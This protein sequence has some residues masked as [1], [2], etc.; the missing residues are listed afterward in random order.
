MHDSRIANTLEVVLKPQDIVVALRLTLP[1]EPW[2]YVTL[3][4]ALHMSPSEAHAAVKRASLAGLVDAETKLARR[5]SLKEFLVHGLKY[6]VPP[7]WTPT[8]RGVPTA[9]AMSPLKA[10]ITDDGSPPVWPHAR[11]KVRGVGLRPLYASVPD[12]TLSDPTFHELLALV[13]AVRAGRAR[14]RE[15]AVKLLSE[16]LR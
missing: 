12:A 8:T 3:G 10:L 11:G 4:T 1:L 14:E 13:D 16:R 5:A 9:H 7:V 6:M 2:T 15:L